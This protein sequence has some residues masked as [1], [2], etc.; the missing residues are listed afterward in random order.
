MF[1]LQN[2][3]KMKFHCIIHSVYGVLL[4]Q[5]KQIHMVS[6]ILNIRIWSTSFMWD[7]TLHAGLPPSSMGTPSSPSLDT[8]FTLWFI[9]SPSL[10]TSWTSAF[11]C[12]T[13]WLWDWIIEEKEMDFF[14][15][16]SLRYTWLFVEM[17]VSSPKQK[18]WKV[19]NDHK[20]E[21]RREKKVYRNHLISLSN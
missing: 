7:P 4:W 2:H 14:F 21:A 20:F 5:P 11:L 18:V 9:L 15:F 1:S 13:Q 16:S 19:H 8:D 3:K 10:P 17:W 12:F 6:I